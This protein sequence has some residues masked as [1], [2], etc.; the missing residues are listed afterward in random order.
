MI[1]WDKLVPWAFDRPEEYQWFAKFM[2]QHHWC[3]EQGTVQEFKG[4]EGREGGLERLLPI[5]VNWAMLQP[6]YVDGACR[7]LHWSEALGRLPVGGRLSIVM[8]KESH[9]FAQLVVGGRKQ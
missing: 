8:G 2:R 9:L 1:A 6:S 7:D 3:L 4:E 5:T